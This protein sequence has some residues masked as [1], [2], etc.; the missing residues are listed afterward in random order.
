MKQLVPRKFDRSRF[1]VDVEISVHNSGSMFVGHALNLAQSGI[2]VFTNRYVP[3][4]QRVELKFRS[5]RNSF[6]VGDNRI[7][8]TVAFARIETDGNIL[9][10][11]FA[12][13]LSSVEMQA[14]KTALGVTVRQ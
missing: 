3:A 11:G 9:G 12:A 10:I 8:G 6:P 13:P 7:F 2:A 4:G 14:L 5:G 1:L